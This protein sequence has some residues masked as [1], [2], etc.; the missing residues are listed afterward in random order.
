M[1]KIEEPDEE[2]ALLMM[3]GIAP[4]FEEHHGVTITDD[5]LVD[6]V[7]LPMRYISGRKLPDKSVSVIDTA[8][9]RVAM[10]FN[11]VSVLTRRLGCRVS[12]V[13]HL[14]GLRP[15]QSNLDLLAERSF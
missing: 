15:C 1:I 2:K 10:G 7:R 12:Q 11:S 8:C 9:A 6:S 14:L 3:R 5:A 13:T 4:L